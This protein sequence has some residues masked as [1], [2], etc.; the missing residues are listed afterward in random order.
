MIYRGQKS[1]SKRRGHTPPSY[2]VKELKEWVMS[3]PEFHVMYDNWVRLDYQTSYRPSI[4]RVDNS[5]GYTMANIR[6]VTWNENMVKGAIDRQRLIA[7]TVKGTDDI[8]EIYSSLTEASL[9]TGAAI[10]N[11][12]KTASGQRKSAGGYG[13]MYL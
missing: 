8:I 4:D 2:T 11:I 5:I 1:R 12:Q 10:C 3:N 6:L 9:Y 13:W 7:Q